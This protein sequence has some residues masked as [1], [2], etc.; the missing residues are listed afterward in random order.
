MDPI[1]FGFEHYDG[2][3]KFRTMDNGGVVDSSGSIE[4]DGSRSRS[5]M[6]AS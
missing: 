5:P 4:L 1:G 6:R 2:L 3:G